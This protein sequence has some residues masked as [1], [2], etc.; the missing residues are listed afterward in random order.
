[1]C[2]NAAMAALWTTSKSIIKPTDDTKTAARVVFL[3]LTA[4]WE[5][6]WTLQLL[7]SR[8]RP[9]FGAHEVSLNAAASVSAPRDGGDVHFAAGDVTT[10]T[11]RWLARVWTFFTPFPPRNQSGDTKKWTTAGKTRRPR[12]WWPR[13][14]RRWSRRSRFSEPCSGECV[15]WPAEG[16]VSGRWLS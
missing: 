9:K 10:E 13:P 3:L 2:W 12:L 14:R 16:Q 8:K 5:Q 15:R 1:M 6:Q 11:R 7:S 4:D